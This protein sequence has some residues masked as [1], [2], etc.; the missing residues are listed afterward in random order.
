MAEKNYSLPAGSK[1]QVNFI[2][3]KFNTTPNYQTTSTG[4]P[5]NQYFYCDLVVGD[6]LF[7][8][9]E[10]V[11]KSKKAAEDFAAGKALVSL[12]PKYEEYLSQLKKDGPVKTGKKKRE[13]GEKE[14]KPGKKQQQNKNKKPK[15]EDTNSYDSGSIDDR[16]IRKSEMSK[17]TPEQ[18]L[19]VDK[20]VQACCNA[21]G[22]FK[23]DHNLSEFKLV[24]HFAQGLLLNDNLRLQG[25]IIFNDIPTQL[26]IQDLF[27]E[28]KEFLS[29]FSCTKIESVINVT[30]GDLSIELHSTF[31][32]A[33]FHDKA[34]YTDITSPTYVNIDACIN[35]LIMMRQ[36]VWYE[37]T[38]FQTSYSCVVARLFIHIM[39]NNV[40][41]QGTSHF[42]LLL[43]LNEAFK[44]NYNYSADNNSIS[45]LLLHVLHYLASGVLLPGFFSIFDPCKDYANINV[46]SPLSNDQEYRIISHFRHDVKQKKDPNINQLIGIASRTDSAKVDRLIKF[47]RSM[48]SAISLRPVT[49]WETMFG[50]LPGADNSNFG[51]LSFNNQ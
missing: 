8:S 50:S 2:C 43:V 28:I 6:E 34:Q 41:L 51:P 32:N 30:W 45:H 49:G 11:C 26:A 31:H 35:A 37:T 3:A 7:Q 36:L 29:D 5:H 25:V 47:A 42:Q 10:E 40:E 4:P 20:I 24:G 27:D 48:L 19:A 13:N 38:Y 1:A 21:L 15:Y 44:S 17:L 12:I 46:F 33:W 14:R 22:Q 18:D 16:L 23:E 39:R 9:K